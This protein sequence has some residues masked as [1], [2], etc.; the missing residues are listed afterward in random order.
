MRM[1][2]MQLSDS[3]PQ[4]LLL[5]SDNK[6]TSFLALMITIPFKQDNVSNKKCPIGHKIRV[7]IGNAMIIKTEIIFNL[8]F[9]SS[10]MLQITSSFC[11]LDNILS[12]RSAYILELAQTNASAPFCIF[13]NPS[14]SK[15]SSKSKSSELFSELW[16]E[17]RERL[18]ESLLK[19]DFLRLLEASQNVRIS[20][21][22]L[23]N[24]IPI[25][26]TIVNGNI[27]QDIRDVTVYTVQNGIL[28]SHLKRV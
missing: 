5:D 22:L 1:V 9:R 28:M 6:F 10:R 26:A 23:V 14:S 24:P 20:I 17:V 19:L 13:V 27:A 7:K 3:S 16:F 11:S 25:I 18:F 4:Q 15:S 21:P 8:S 12:V 2:S